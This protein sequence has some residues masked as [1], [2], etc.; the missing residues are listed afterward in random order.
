MAEAE[1]D[2]ARMNTRE[3]MTA[4][5]MRYPSPAWSFLP[6]V[7]NGTGYLKTPRTADAIAMA[8]WPS[9]GLEVHGFEVKC[10]R[11]DWLR[12]LKD[13]AKADEIFQFCDRWWLVIGDKAIVRPG[14]LPPS[15]GLLIPRGASSLVLEQEASKLGA[16]EPDRLFLAAILRR[17]HEVSIPA[18]DVDARV[19]KA[20]EEGKQGA[21]DEIKRATDALTTYKADV[22]EFEA[23]S[24]VKL[25]D[26]WTHG[27][28]GRA[29]RDVIDF[30]PEHFRRAIEA[31]RLWAERIVE[32]CKR[33]LDGT[34][35]PKESLL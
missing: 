6:Q 21:A 34:S 14:E 20:F 30:G 18:D 35:P 25:L 29:V 12:E 10:S 3:I 23:A 24:G 4:L 5:A 28:I 27:N 15:W 13:P 26:Q 31:H 22:A 7:R 19:A 17:V 16:V 8:L 11:S 33:Q 32:D 1:G 2:D 9:R